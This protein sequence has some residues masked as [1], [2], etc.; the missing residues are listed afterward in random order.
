MIGNNCL[1]SII[2]ICLIGLP[3]D[4]FID[5]SS[6]GAF[7]KILQD[8]DICL[9]DGFEQ[10][11]DK[12]SFCNQ[13]NFEKLNFQKI[14]IGDACE[15]RSNFKTIVFRLDLEI[16]VVLVIDSVGIVKNIMRA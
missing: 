4:H 5:G 12:I 15:G 7:N 3:N 2:K 1:L 9:I 14:T 8:F 16:M 6:L 10:R 13:K 11:M